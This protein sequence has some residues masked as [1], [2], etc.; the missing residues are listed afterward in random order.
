MT[1]PLKN[2]LLNLPFASL[3]PS[4]QLLVRLALF[5]AVH[6]LRNV[7][8]PAARVTRRIL[9]DL[10]HAEPSTTLQQV[11]D[12]ELPKVDR[13]LRLLAKTRQELEYLRIALNE[14]RN[15]QGPTT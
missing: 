12:D 13:E 8:H 4:A 5:L 7:A 11:V 10:T 1:Q 15:T 9:R 3:H 14:W 2:S 6:G